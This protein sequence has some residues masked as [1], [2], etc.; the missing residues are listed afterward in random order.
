MRQSAIALAPIAAC[1]PMWRRAI[2]WCS[3]ALERRRQRRALAELDDH[4]L[5]D[6]GLTRDDAREQA[7]K[8]FW[9]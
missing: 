1:A 5:K 9:R 6:I 2:G 4:L 7:A 8:P 3:A